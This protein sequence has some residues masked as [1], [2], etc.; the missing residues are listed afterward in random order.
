M[1]V[2][3]KPNHLRMDLPVKEQKALTD[4]QGAS[5]WSL[6]TQEMD[7]TSLAE[8]HSARIPPSFTEPLTQASSWRMLLVVQVADVGRR[9]LH[10]IHGCYQDR[11]VLLV[12]RSTS[13]LPVFLW[14]LTPTWMPVSDG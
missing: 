14:A 1:V 3:E 7:Q 2:P 9:R 4:S 6:R 11:L 13:F 5:P 12:T 10:L 8:F